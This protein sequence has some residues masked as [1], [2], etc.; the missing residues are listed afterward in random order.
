MVTGNKVG[1]IEVYYLEEKPEL[2][3]GPFLK[4]ERE[5][6]DDIA[7]KVGVHDSAQEV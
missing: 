5:L 2:D 3:E 4:Q 1:T 7:R 6:I